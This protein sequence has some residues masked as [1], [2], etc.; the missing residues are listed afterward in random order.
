MI[1]PLA[2]IHR[3]YQ[4]GSD[5]ERV[6]SLHSEDVTGL[7]LELL[8]AHPEMNLDRTFVA[9]ISSTRSMGFSLKAI[10]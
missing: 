8:D 10:P 9:S 2:L 4:P 1:D 3:Y 6:L 5:I 7:A